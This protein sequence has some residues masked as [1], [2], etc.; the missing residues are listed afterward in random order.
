VRLEN[1]IDLFLALG[2]G[3]DEPDQSDGVPPIEEIVASGGGR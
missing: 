3:F 1:R 2:G